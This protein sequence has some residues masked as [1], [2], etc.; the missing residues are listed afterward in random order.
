LCNGNK[1]A[2]NTGNGIGVEI[3]GRKVLVVYV[4]GNEPAE[5]INANEDQQRMGDFVCL[6]KAYGNS[7]GYFFDNNFN[8]SWAL[9]RPYILSGSKMGQSVLGMTNTR[10]FVSSLYVWH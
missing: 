2:R 8:F 3:S 9:Q 6:N 7:M 4:L 1:D 5:A 10:A